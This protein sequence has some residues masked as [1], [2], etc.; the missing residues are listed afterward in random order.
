MVI[1]YTIIGYFYRLNHPIPGLEKPS[2]FAFI[3]LLL[4]G[5]L[6]FIVSVAYLKNYLA[7]SNKR[8]KK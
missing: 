1:I 5:I 4:L 3:M 2:F 8:K 6:F 7:A